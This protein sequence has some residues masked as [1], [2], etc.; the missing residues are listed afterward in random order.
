[1]T[2]EIFILSLI[3]V[4]CG[5]QE[6]SGSADSGSSQ[7]GTQA[8]IAPDL[9][10]SLSGPPKVSRALASVGILVGGA[11]EATSQ[12]HQLGNLVPLTASGQIVEQWASTMGTGFNGEVT[13]LLVASDKIWVGGDFTEFNGVS[14]VRFGAF[15]LRWKLG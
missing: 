14:A 10:V 3:L 5:E 7:V 2:R 4:A 9:S 15:E 6:G 13:S 12:D 8:E 11:F 1:M